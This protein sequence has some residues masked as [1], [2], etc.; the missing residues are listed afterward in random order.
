MNS[1]EEKPSVGVSEKKILSL[2]GFARRAGKIVLGYDRIEQKPKSCR[3]LVCASDMAERTEK[4]IGLLGIETV[5][6]SL[7]KKEFGAALGA[8]EISVVGVTDKN[9]A[10]QIS[11]YAK[12]SIC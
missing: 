4:N 2:L 3:I 6:L 9:F 7:T 1:P 5:H 8:I 12:E 11:T 10:N